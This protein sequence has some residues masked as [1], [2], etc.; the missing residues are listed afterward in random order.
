MLLHAVLLCAVWVGLVVSRCP[1]SCSGHGSC[2]PSNICTCYPQWDGGAADCSQRMDV[3]LYSFISLSSME[4]N[5]SQVYVRLEL[6]GQIKL[7][8]LIRHT[9]Q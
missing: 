7:M 1:N 3:V 2:G 5:M 6:P 8:Q 9:R 4:I